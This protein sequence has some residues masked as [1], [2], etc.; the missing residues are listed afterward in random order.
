MVNLKFSNS[1]NNDYL[2][3]SY[4]NEYTKEDIL[5]EDDENP[6]ASM[7]NLSQ[8]QRSFGGSKQRRDMFK[9]D[10]SFVLIF[11]RKDSPKNPGIQQLSTDPFVKY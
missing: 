6:V 7:A 10:P 8:T 11:V 4:N 9:K 1:L 2:A 5:K 3:V